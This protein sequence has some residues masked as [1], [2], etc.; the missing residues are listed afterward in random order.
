MI[1]LA[2]ALHLDSHG[3][4]IKGKEGEI[5]ISQLSNWPG[6]GFDDYVYILIQ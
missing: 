4:I 3:Q 6:T 5:N 1:P 2:C